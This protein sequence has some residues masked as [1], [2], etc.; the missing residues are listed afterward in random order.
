MNALRMIFE[1]VH[2]V[3]APARGR[4][5]SGRT[6]L[7]SGLVPRQARRTFDAAI[8]LLG[9]DFPEWRI[10]RLPAPSGHTYAAMSRGVTVYASAPAELRT[11]I[12]AVEDEPPPAFVRGYLDMDMAVNR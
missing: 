11:R 3:I 8:E 4:H 6:P 1:L 2:A 12:H 9:R 10:I 7:P 5:C